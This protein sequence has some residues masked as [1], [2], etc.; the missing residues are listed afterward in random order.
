MLNKV[1]E[2]IK[3][4]IWK[5]KYSLYKLKCKIKKQEEYILFGTPLH[6]TLGDQA[7]AI[8]EYEEEMKK[9]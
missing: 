7:I 4:I 6:G 3:E 1:K 8:A 9:E 2:K 5:I